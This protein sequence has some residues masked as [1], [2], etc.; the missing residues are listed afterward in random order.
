MATHPSILAWEIPWTEELGGLQ[1]LGL[2]RIRHDL[3]KDTVYLH[4]KSLRWQFRA[5]RLL[6]R[7]CFSHMVLP[8]CPEGGRAGSKLP[9]SFMCRFQGLT[10]IEYFLCFK[11]IFIEVYLLYN[12]LLVSVIQQRESDI[13]THRHPPPPPFPLFFEFLSPSGHHRAVSRVACPHQ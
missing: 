13:D 7:M 1:S 5:L 3:A 12:V 9:S 2:Q 10:C 8:A 6:L 11:S 4:V